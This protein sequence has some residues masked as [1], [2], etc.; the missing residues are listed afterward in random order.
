MRE[1][2]GFKKLVSKVN[3]REICLC[4]GKENFKRCKINT[5]KNY[6]LVNAFK[7]FSIWPSFFTNHMLHSVHNKHNS[8]VKC[9]QLLDLQSDLWKSCNLDENVFIQALCLWN[10]RNDKFV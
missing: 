6:F 2:K 4:N 8:K 10:C 3:S 9:L 1:M 5:E 7:S